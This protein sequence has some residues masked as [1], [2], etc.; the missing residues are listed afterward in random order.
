MHLDANNDRPPHYPDSE[1]VFSHV[2]AV[3]YE[4]DAAGVPLDDAR[5]DL[6]RH[7]LATA[8]ALVR[9]SNAAR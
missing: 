6:P 3:R 5:R 4:L 8:N 7:M 9:E 2:A 1:A